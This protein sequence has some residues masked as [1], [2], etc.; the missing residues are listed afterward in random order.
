MIII[1]P[2]GYKAAISLWEGGTKMGLERVLLEFIDTMF[3]RKV[4]ILYIHA[5]KA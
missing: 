4:L 3:G 5:T 1:T 2:T